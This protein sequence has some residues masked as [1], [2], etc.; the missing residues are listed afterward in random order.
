MSSD[1]F[2]KEFSLHEIGETG[3]GSELQVGLCG[4]A[5]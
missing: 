3:G 5:S 4:L 2:E 1:W